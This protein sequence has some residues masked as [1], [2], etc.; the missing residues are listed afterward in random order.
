MRAEQHGRP[1]STRSRWLTKKRL[2]VGGVVTTAAM[3]SAFA[4]LGSAATADERPTDAESAAHAHMLWLEGIGLDVAGAGVTETEFAGTAATDD[5]EL[6]VSL[7]EGLV[8]LNLG[9]IDLPLIKPGEDGAGLLHLG[10]LGVAGSHSESS[11]PTQSLA[12][13][14]LLTE[15]GALDV[16]AYDG[17]VGDPAYVDLTA[18][19]EQVLGAGALEELL[20]EARIEV[21]AV[22]SQIEKNG[23]DVTSSYRIADLN[24][25]LTSPLVGDVTTLVDDIVGGVVDPLNDAIGP[26]GAIGGI[27]NGLVEDLDLSLPLV[28]GLTATLE[29]PL[30]LDVSSL[31]DSVR[32]GLLQEPLDN[33]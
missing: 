15:E 12:A 25:D 17:G 23:T 16:D 26:E 4:G 31:T 19:I 2:A 1:E 8:D 7:L 21:G 5:S 18:L 13:T 27:V 20:S 11:S 22:G 3:V 32:E 9:S 10:A 24:L 30:S 14:G 28:G 33:Y 29:T 6:D